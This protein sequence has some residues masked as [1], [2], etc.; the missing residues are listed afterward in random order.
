MFDIFAIK[1]CE[2]GRNTIVGHLPREVSRITKFTLD[3]GAIVSTEISSD[4]YK[5]DLLFKVDWKSLVKLLLK[6][7]PLLT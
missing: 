4:H 7:L 1:A 3:R 5:N 2:N 6:H